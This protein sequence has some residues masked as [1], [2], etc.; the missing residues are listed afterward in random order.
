[1]VSA[2]RV[3]AVLVFGIGYVYGDLDLTP[4]L[5]EYDLEG[6]KLH[7]LA[8]TDGQTLIT[9][10][11]P[12]NWEYFGGGNR[13]VLRP[14]SEAGAEAEIS[15]TGIR[16]QADF[17]ESE[18]KQLTADVVASLPHEAT[19]ITIVSQQLNPLLI[20]RKKTFLVIVS[21]DYYSQ[22]YERSVMFLDRNSEQIKFQLTCYRS[23]FQKLQ[24]AFEGSHYSWQNL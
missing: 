10:A 23:A 22:S 6:V 2:I 15:V 11:P 12:K 16:H 13:L 3:S 14:R 21:Y 20:G 18:V 4:R 19:N 17:D 1:M 7:Q 8:F 24:R 5:Q 9:Y